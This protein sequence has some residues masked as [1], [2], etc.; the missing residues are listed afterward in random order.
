[1]IGSS[2]NPKIRQTVVICGRLVTT[3]F[4]FSFFFLLFFFLSSLPIQKIPRS[5]S[6]IKM[7]SFKIF[8][9]QTPNVMVPRGLWSVLGPFFAFFAAFGIVRNDS[10]NHNSYCCYFNFE[11]KNSHNYP[12][13]IFEIIENHFLSLDCGIIRLGRLLWHYFTLLI[14]F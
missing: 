8:E 1:M 4:S 2:K 11:S 13:F 14:T 5:N 7:F 12:L 9:K 10:L 3:L 6:K